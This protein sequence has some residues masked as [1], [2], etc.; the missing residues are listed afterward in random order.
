MTAAALEQKVLKL[1]PASR[2]RLAEKILESVDDYASPEVASSWQREIARRV[3]E[4]E[5]GTVEGVPADEVF[6]EARRR[7]HE[8]RRVSSARRKRAH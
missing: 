6:A 7:L 1:P 4:I 5:A 8:A 2:V 3:K